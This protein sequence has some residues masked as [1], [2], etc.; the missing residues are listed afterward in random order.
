GD[1][2]PFDDGAVTLSAD[3]SEVVLFLINRSLEQQQECSIS[4]A[5]AP[6]MTVLECVSLSGF[7][8]ESI[9]TADATPVHP[10][11]LTEYQLH[12]GKFE[13]TLPKFSW[14]MVRL[15]LV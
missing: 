1:S 7:T 11:T 14:N 12:E 9:N 10:A 3:E 6:A 15:K 5:N 13:I 8:P 4:V 2:I